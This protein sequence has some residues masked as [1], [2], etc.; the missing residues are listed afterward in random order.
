[1]QGKDGDLIETRLYHGCWVLDNKHNMIYVSLKTA[2]IAGF[3]ADE[4]KTTGATNITY[5]IANYAT[6]DAGHKFYYLSTATAAAVSVPA[7]YDE[8]VATSYTEIVSADAV[9][10]TVSS[11]YFGAL[12]EVDENGR[13]IRFETIQAH[14]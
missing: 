10:K 4:L 7:A 8:F 3:S 5:T 14:A 1:V 13:V 12:A 2:T 9:S 6:R 11:G